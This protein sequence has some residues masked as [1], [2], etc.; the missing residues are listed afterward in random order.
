[1]LRKANEL[2]KKRV[3]VIDYFSVQR[4]IRLAMRVSQD[5]MEYLT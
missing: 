4:V 1:M 3:L 5:A 2:K